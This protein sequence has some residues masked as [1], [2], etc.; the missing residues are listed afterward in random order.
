M[1]FLYCA[2]LCINVIGW[3]LHLRRFAVLTGV[4]LRRQRM[5]YDRRMKLIFTINYLRTILT[6]I[7]VGWEGHSVYSMEPA[8]S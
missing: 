5:V 2:I 7:V 4:T 6:I 1:L 8:W 3:V